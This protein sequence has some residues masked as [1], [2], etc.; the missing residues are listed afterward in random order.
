[1]QMV[2]GEE[3]LVLHR[4]G[5]AISW[6]V[7]QLGWRTVCQ[8]LAASQYWSKFVSKADYDKIYDR[9][10]RNMN[11]AKLGIDRDRLFEPGILSRV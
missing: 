11:F 9:L 6:P 10:Y 1:L 3:H 4:G 8:A 7:Q 5:K 2:D